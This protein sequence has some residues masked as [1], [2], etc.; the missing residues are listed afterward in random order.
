M[1]YKLNFRVKI[2]ISLPKNFRILRLKGKNDQ[3]NKQTEKKTINKQ[4]QNKPNSF[5]RKVFY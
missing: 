4:H 1:L 2:T 5:F 3:E